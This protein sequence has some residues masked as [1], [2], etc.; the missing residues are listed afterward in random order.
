MDDMTTLTRLRADLPDPTPQALAAARSRL[1]ERIDPATA[2][3][4]GPAPRRRRPAPWGRVA[5]AAAAAALA[6][7][8]GVVTAGSGS[9]SGSGHEVATPGAA[10]GGGAPALSLAATELDLAAVNTLKSGDPAVGPGQYTRVVTDSWRGEY[11]DG[12][13]FL[14][15]GRLEVWVPA[16]ANGTWYWR[17]SGRLG[18]K[19][20]TGADRRYMAAH[21]PDAFRPT[22]FLA[23]G[24]NGR[25]D[26][27][28]PADGPQPGGCVVTATDRRRP[29]QACVSPGPDW[30]FPTPAW[31]A[32]QPRDPQALL[33]AIEAAQPKPVPGTRPKAD[34]PT[35]AFFQIAQTLSTGIAPA[36]LRAALYRAA[37]KIPGIKL[38]S[39]TA[40]IDGR[41]GI[42]IGRLEPFGYLRQEILFDATGG[43]F[44]GAR[45]VVVH[46]NADVAHLPVGATYSSTAVT[47]SV[48]GNPHLF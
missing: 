12:I 15:K 44:I 35:L 1:T 22:V 2:R 39:A 18:T 46:S 7:G 36:D 14:Q 19:F 42:A 43:Q 29:D 27:A 37:V 10:T 13:S 4:G 6:A 5:V 23:S 30:D 47:V 28:L 17:E 32:T 16:D 25:Q 20:A 38:V 48:T 40:N 21:H 9:G 34:T 41:K 33:A 45:E 11:V 24:H 26:K 8:I 31:L 3:P